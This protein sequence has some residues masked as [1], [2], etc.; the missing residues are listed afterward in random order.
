[1]VL[2]VARYLVVLLKRPG[3]QAQYWVALL[4]QGTEDRFGALH[5]WGD[6]ALGAGSS[7][8]IFTEQAAM[9][10]RSFSPRCRKVT[11]MMPVH[12]VERLRVDKARRLLLETRPPMKRIAQRCGFGSEETLRCSFLRLL[13]ITSNDSKSTAS[14]PR[15]LQQSI[16]EYAYFE[17]LVPS[18]NARTLRS[19]H[20]AC[21]IR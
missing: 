14:V 1:V 5:A 11:G 10:A 20:A 18:P 12:A 4:L 8:P 2:A 19:S 3:G 21:P 7:L 15:Q 9:S 6:C 16:A 13:M 17:C